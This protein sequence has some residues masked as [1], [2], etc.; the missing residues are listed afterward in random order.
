MEKADG[1]EVDMYVSSKIYGGGGDKEIDLNT[2]I[3]YPYTIRSSCSQVPNGVNDKGEKLQGHGGT[4]PVT[5]RI[6]F[7]QLSKN[8]AN[9]AKLLMYNKLTAIGIE[10]PEPII[11]W[12]GENSA[13]PGTSGPAWVEGGPV[14]SEALKKARFVKIEIAIG[15]KAK[16][17]A[18]EPIPPIVFK[19]GDFKVQIVQDVDSWCG[20]FCKLL[21]IPPPR[22]PKWPRIKWPSW[23][24]GG[25]KIN[26]TACPKF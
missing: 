1:N 3:D 15:F 18:P 12:E 17:D 26:T 19:V 22:W 7:E 4:V 24:I 6:S 5:E 10:M 23:K 11:N 8:R 25:G 2:I 13:I 16:G 21:R 14:D 20:I 9:T